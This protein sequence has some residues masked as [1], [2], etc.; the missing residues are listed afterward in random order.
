MQ[1]LVQQPAHGYCLPR[2]QH[3]VLDMLA[4][5]ALMPSFSRRPLLS[6]PRQAQPG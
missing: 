3:L 4:C 2:D 1:G 6:H 5:G